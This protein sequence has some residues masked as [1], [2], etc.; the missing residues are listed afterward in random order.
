MSMKVIVAPNDVNITRYIPVEPETE[1]GIPILTKTGLKM[2]PPPSPN[3]PEIH[4]PIKATVTNLLITLKE[5]L[6]S[7]LQIPLLYLILKYYSY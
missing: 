4:P 1:G 6:R 7:L 2:A 5:S 3:D